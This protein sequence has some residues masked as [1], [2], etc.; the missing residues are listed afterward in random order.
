MRLPVTEGIETPSVANLR[1]APVGCSK[2]EQP[3]PEDEAR[4]LSPSPPAGHRRWEHLPHPRFTLFATPRPPECP[5]SSG[6]ECPPS[7]LRGAAPSYGPGQGREPIFPAGL[8]PVLREQ[9]LELRPGHERLHGLGQRYAAVSPEMSPPRQGHGDPVPGGVQD[10]G[11]G[12]WGLER[13]D[14]H[15]GVSGRSTRAQP[16][17]LVGRSGR[18]R[19]PNPET[20][21]LKLPSG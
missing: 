16:S 7:R 2:G 17:S 19:K 10:V 13:V 15:Q 3:A 9:G 14:D 5:P 12:A 11:V 8:E 20:T 4:G 1:C 6:P 18:L 21:P